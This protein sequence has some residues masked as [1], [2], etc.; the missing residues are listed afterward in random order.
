MFR[1]YVFSN[2]GKEHEKSHIS[3]PNSQ[4]STESMTSSPIASSSTSTPTPLFPPGSLWMNFFV[5]TILGLC[6]SLSKYFYPSASL[7]NINM[8]YPVIRKL[9]YKN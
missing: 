5:V 7:S 3:I 9:T 8:E 1:S 2:Q 6:G 4:A